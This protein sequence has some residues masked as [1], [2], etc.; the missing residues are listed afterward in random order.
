MAQQGPDDRRG[1]YSNDDRRG[2]GDDERRG[3]GRFNRP[4]SCSVVADEARRGDTLNVR[5]RSTERRGDAVVVAN[6]N[7]RGPNSRQI[8]RDVDLNAGGNGRT[9]FTIPRRA[10]WV[11]VDV[12]IRDGDRRFQWI[13]CSDVERLR[14]NRG[15][16]GPWGN[17]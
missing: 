11:T 10:S 15:G 17:R 13:R 2:G 6:F 7:T 16:N 14:D 1:G 8:D 5:I 9:E 3:N 12:F 4:G